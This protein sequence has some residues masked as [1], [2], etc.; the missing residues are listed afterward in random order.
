MKRIEQR[1]WFARS[2][3]VLAAW[4]FAPAVV[5]AETGAVVLWNRLGSEAE[6]T[7]SEI[8]PNGVIVPG[9]I[10][11]AYLPVQFDNGLHTY[12]NQGGGFQ[13]AVRF[14]FDS[15]NTLGDRGTVGFWVRPDH[16]SG[17]SG[18][19][20]WSNYYE[21]PSGLYMGAGINWYFSHIRYELCGTGGCVLLDAPNSVTRFAA[22]EVVHVALAWDLRGIEGARDTVRGYFNGEH[23]V[24]ASGKWIA[25]LPLSGFVAGNSDGIQ[26]AAIDNLVIYDFAKTDFSDRFNENP[27]PSCEGVLPKLSALVSNKT[28]TQDARTWTVTLSNKS[29]CPAL[30]AQIDGL[31]LTQTYGV[32]CTPVITSPASF[33]LKLGDIAARDKA[34]GDVT[35]N[36]SA[37]PSTARFTA[38]ITYSANDGAVKGSKTLN[39]QYR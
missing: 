18:L 16:G 8:G 26:G 25:G 24:S 35:I 1:V 15:R 39:N 20:R 7:N 10:P 36:F 6:V 5:Q 34:S 28:G 33:P 27:T 11:M 37:C 29:Y 23:V 30:K 3:L 17:D 14:L 38:R 19:Y 9:S 31:K 22:G 32:A 12:G 4:L 13:E 2:A 21:Q